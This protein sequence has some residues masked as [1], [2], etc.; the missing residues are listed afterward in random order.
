M[1]LFFFYTRGE[2]VLCLRAC[3]GVGLLPQSYQYPN[4][5]EGAVHIGGQLCGDKECP[6]CGVTKSGRVWRKVPESK[7]WSVGTGLSITQT[8]SANDSI[9]N[10]SLDE[11]PKEWLP[12]LAHKL[13][14]TNQLHKILV[15]SAQDLCRFLIEFASYLSVCLIKGH[16]MKICIYVCIFFI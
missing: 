10:N 15:D 5:L 4:L 1:E 14:P 9:T 2:C 11:N 3:L 16:T 13:K 12:T 8:A 6:F 7:A